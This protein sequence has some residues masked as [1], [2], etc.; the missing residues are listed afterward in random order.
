MPLNLYICRF[1][2]IYQDH[3]QDLSESITWA[4]FVFTVLLMN[5]HTAGFHT[6]SDDGFIKFVEMDVGVGS[7]VA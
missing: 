2:D 4:Y 3:Y 6:L 5:T 7:Q 1:F